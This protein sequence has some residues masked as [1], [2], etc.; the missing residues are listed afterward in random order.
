MLL[1]FSDT[2]L[3][4]AL[5]D[6]LMVGGSTRIPAVQRLVRGV[7]GVDTR[8]TAAV[9]RRGTGSGSGAVINPDEAVN[10]DLLLCPAL[11]PLLLFPD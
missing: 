1:A 6:V 2:I 4:Q 11:S 3:L 9:H 7:C 10:R 5:D 8:S